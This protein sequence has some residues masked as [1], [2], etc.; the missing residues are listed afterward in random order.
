MSIDVSKEFIV[1]LFRVYIIYEC[2]PTFVLTSYFAGVYCQ[3]YMKKYNV[4][5]LFSPEIPDV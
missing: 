5:V 2:G 3:D 1:P 4:K